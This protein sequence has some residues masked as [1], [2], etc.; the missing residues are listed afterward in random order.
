MSEHV[1][2]E[3]LPGVAVLRLLRPEKKNAL[4][5][6]MYT[7]L[8][9]GLGQA[10]ADPDV[11]AAVL[12]GTDSVFTAGNDIGDF[13]KAAST[14]ADMSP[15]IRF[16]HALAEFPKPLVAGVS[17]VAIGIGTTLLLHCDLVYADASAR[18]KTP[19]VDLGLTPE[20]GSSLLLPALLGQRAAAEWLLL[21]DEFGPEQARAAGLVN[22]V[23][24]SA[25]EAALAAARRLA[26][27]PGAA[28]VEA[29]RLM[30]RAS[31]AA[32]TE[33]IN[34]EA[35]VFAARLRSPEAMAAFMAFRR[36]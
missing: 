15:P 22:A 14:G 28:L 29:K 3:S 24:A 10:A 11:R 4:T 30:K 26:D 7:A 36:K 2:T 1:T 32:I 20:G 31:A 6:A 35:E 5:F 33:A 12:L 17:G 19:F 9:D 16:L 21:G 13:V 34:L 18:F 23:V 8:I 25:S 27:K